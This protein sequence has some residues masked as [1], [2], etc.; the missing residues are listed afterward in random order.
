M[1]RPLRPILR[2]PW[3]FREQGILVEGVLLLYTAQAEKQR[4]WILEK[5]LREQRREIRIYLVIKQFLRYGVLPHPGCLDL[6]REC[7]SSMLDLAP[8]R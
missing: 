4:P 8:S 7:G 2:W 6:S 1:M 3:Y 5:P